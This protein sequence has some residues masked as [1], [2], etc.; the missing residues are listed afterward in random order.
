MN[1]H[2]WGGTPFDTV[3][4]HGFG[5]YHYNT[6][7]Q[8]TIDFKPDH[9]TFHLSRDTGC[10][11][12]PFCGS[13]LFPGVEATGAVSNGSTNGFVPTFDILF[14]PG[15][16]VGS[17]ATTVEG[18]TGVFLAGGFV[19]SG[20]V[21]SVIASVPVPAAAWLLGAALGGLGWAR[22]RAT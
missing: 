21:S 17:A 9:V 5:S 3:F 6:D 20:S 18:F 14:A 7:S 8:W 13:N 4:D 19:S 11:L 12:P 10:H 1:Q 15:Q 2:T 16:Q 22:R